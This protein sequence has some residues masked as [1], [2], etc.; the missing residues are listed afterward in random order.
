MGTQQSVWAGLNVRANSVAHSGP[1][2]LPQVPFQEKR[3]DTG[4]DEVP[5]VHLPALISGESSWGGRPEQV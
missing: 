4:P 3:G 5:N 2:L 1:S